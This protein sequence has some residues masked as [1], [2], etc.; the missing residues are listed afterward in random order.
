MS[1][2][3]VE[4]VRE[5]FEATNRG[6]FAA[7]MADWDDDIEVTYG[8]DAGIASAAGL[9]LRAGTYSGRAAVGEFFGEWFRM[10][11]PVH[12]DL[13]QVVGGDDAV[14]VAARHT[15]HGRG[16]GVE[17]VEDVFYEYRLRNGKIVRITFH[18]SWAEALEA[19]GLGE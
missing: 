3:N 1:Q 15:A 14:A 13:L 8:G 17:V 16:S 18:P 10:F 19:V 6:D 7:P 2:E 9:D 11:R 4:M 12:F 5:Q